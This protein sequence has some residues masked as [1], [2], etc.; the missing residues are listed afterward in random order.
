MRAKNPKF[1]NAA[2]TLVNLILEHPVHGA[3]PFTASPDDGEAHGRELFARAI[4]GEFGQIAAYDGPSAA[5]LSAAARRAEIVA[6]LAAIDGGSIRALR[7]KAAGKGKP[8]DDTKLTALDAEADALR[9]ELAGL[10]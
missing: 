7:A 9:V 3:I 8:A 4:A 10:A 6:R 1:A 2:G 5:Q